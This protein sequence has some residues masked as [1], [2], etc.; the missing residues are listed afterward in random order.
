MKVY[1]I[2]RQNNAESW[3]EAANDFFRSRLSDLNVVR[4]LPSLNNTPTHD[5]IDGQLVRFR[6]MIQDMYDPE[7]YL[8]EFVVRKISSILQVYLFSITKDT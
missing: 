8:S 6:C 2:F 1:L 7:F 5:L 4:S 3:E